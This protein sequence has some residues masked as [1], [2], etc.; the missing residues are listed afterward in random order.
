MKSLLMNRR[1]SIL[2]IVL[3]VF[4]LLTLALSITSFY[5]L[6]SASQL[7]SISLLL[8]QKNLEIFLV[9]YYSD[10]VQNDILLSDNY[11]FNDNEVISTVD[12][13]GNYY[14]VTTFVQTKQMQYSFLVWVEVDTGA[15]LKF[16]YV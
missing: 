14:E 15:I 1:G 12:D 13:L 6:Q 5:I 2:Q 3:I 7:H 9:K 11:S 4:M 16:E 8:K 10:T